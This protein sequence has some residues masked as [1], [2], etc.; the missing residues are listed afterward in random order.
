MPTRGREVSRIRD[1]A[2]DVMRRGQTALVPAWR[3][4]MTWRAVDVTDEQAPRS[5]MVLAPH[6]DD[7]TL[8]CGALIAR[9][10]AAGAPVHVVIA[11]DGRSSHP[12]SVM[13]S[14]ALVALRAAEVTQACRLLGVPERDLTRLGIPDE[15]LDAQRDQLTDRLV[16]MLDHL[17][18]DDVFVCSARDWHPDHQALS[19][20]T[21]A[22]ADAAARRPRLLEYCVWWWVEGPWLRH[23]GRPWSRA[24]IEL[25]TEPVESLRSRRPERV[26]TAQFRATKRAALA[27]HRSQL[28]N[29]TGEDDWAVLEPG[30]VTTLVGPWELFFPI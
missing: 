3:S 13:G 8:G 25:V 12:T 22:A 26:A 21:R 19:R 11:G 7:E 4:A 14:P 28:E 1:V 24:A 18:P 23:A 5:A 16:R 17:R 29:I 20:A 27:A 2:G 30:M 9:R 15:H 10:R 6:P